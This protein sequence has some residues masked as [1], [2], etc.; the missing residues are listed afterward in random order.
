MKTPA[1][2]VATAILGI[3]AYQCGRDHAAKDPAKV[4]ADDDV[5]VQPPSPGATRA[6]VVDTFTLGSTEAEVKAVMGAPTR[7]DDVF[8]TWSYGFSEVEFADGKV[9]G[10][11]DRSHRLKLRMDPHDPQAA[12]AAKARGT[13]GK[14]STKDEVIGVMGVPSHIEP[15]F[16]QW[17]YDFSEIDFAG[18]RVAGWSERDV[19]LPVR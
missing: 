4:E 1:L 6:P 12:A 10:W 9:V 17:S 8:A 15:V 18:D 11:W 16:D 2:L 14:G 3:G 19:K 13:F 7:L 5:T